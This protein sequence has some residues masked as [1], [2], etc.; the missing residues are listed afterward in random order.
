MKRN[1]PTGKLYVVATPI[2]NLKDITLRA[3][4][5]LKDVDYIACEDTRHTSI[6]AKSY[7]IKTK[8]IS[9][10]QHNKI[11]K[12]DY[13]IAKLKDGKNV[14]LV[15]DAGTPGISDPGYFII[16]ECIKENIEI[17]PIPGVSALTAALSISGVP[18]KNVFFNGF[19]PGK[20]GKRKKRLKQLSEIDSTIVLYISKHKIEKVITVM[21]DFFQN[22]K[23]VLTRELTKK[24][25]EIIRGDINDIYS[26]VEN[27]KPRGEFTLIISPS[28]K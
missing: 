13:F 25:E 14:A 15:T 4:Q 7:N 23:I 6:L 28:Q 24:F 10:H 20:K 26:Y 22:R 18:A 12:T 11:K 27:N 19:L 16:K 21:R 9:Y 8:L 5:I 1:K 17:E 2:G 3:I